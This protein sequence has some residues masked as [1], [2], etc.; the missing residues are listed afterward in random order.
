MKEIVFKDADREAD[1]EFG[2]LLHHAAY[3]EVVTRQF[4]S[5]EEKIQDDFFKEGWNRAPHKIILVD[6]NAVGIYSVAEYPDHIFFSELQISPEYQ[7]K[8]LG[9]KIMKEQ[10]QYAKKRDL[11][12][13]LQVLQENRAQELYLRLGFLVIENTNTHVKMEWKGLS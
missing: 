2:R 4:G 7:G 13:R 12:L 8:G 5:W 11:A 3:Q 10:M 9:T 6:G 1:Y